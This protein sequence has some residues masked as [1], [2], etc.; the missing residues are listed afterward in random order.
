MAKKKIVFIEAMTEGNLVYAFFLKK[1]PLL[2]PVLLATMLRDRGHEV[3]VFG[4]NISGS[5]FDN[6]EMLGKVLEADFVGVSTLTPAANRAYTIGQ[7][8]RELG[9]K[10]RLVIGGSHVTFFPQEALR[11]YPC[12][13]CGEAENVIVELAEGSQT[14]EGIVKG[15]PVE[16]LDALPT[17]D[18]R[19]VYDHENLWKPC[20]FREF[21]E[22]PIMTQRGCPYNC[23]YCS[24]SQMFGHRIRQRSVDKV[25][26]DVQFYYDQGYRSLFWFDDNFTVDHGR[27]C[28]LLERIKGM[29]LRW[30]AECRI[31]FPWHDPAKRKNLDTRMLKLVKESGGHTAYVGYETLDETTARQWHK[32]YGGDSPLIER[33]AQDTRILQDAGMWVHAMFVIGPQHKMDTWQR[34]VDFCIQNRIP[35]IHFSLLTPFPG[36]QI[37]DDM[38]NDLIFTDFPRDWKYYDASHLT[39]HHRLEGNE[40]VQNAMTTYHLKYYRSLAHQG[41]RIR[42]LLKGWGSLPKKLVRVVHSA[43]RVSGVFRMMQQDNAAFLEETARRGEHYLLPAADDLQAPAA[44][45]ATAPDDSH[46]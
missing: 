34:T 14:P 30:D 27:T 23:R 10:G 12:V 4:E 13:V 3:T 37:F 15:S 36:S 24:V 7:R 1:W 29:K 19:L 35:S 20:L 41:D 9:C 2:G 31:D 8:L 38:K 32:G 17:P 11:Y 18:L 21:Y 5:I 45:P 22:V 28:E 6:S 16:D 43:V 26:Q 33:M 40:A 42:L 46:E 25:V 39:Y 44:T